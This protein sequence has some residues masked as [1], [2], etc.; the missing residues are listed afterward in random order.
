ML[1]GY[2]PTP[3]ARWCTKNLKIIPM[4]QFIGDDEAISYVGIRADEKRD[5]YISRRPNIKPINGTM[6][7]P[8]HGLYIFLPLSDR[9]S[10]P[11]L[12]SNKYS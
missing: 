11:L 1:G 7:P 6:F 2:L 8:Y 12:Y 3:K 5:G 9:S 10:L 4:E